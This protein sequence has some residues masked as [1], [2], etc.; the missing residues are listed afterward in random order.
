MIEKSLGKESYSPDPE[1]RKIISEVI[2]KRKS[3][4]WRKKIREALEYPDPDI[5]E[6]KITKWIDLSE[7]KS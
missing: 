7:D 1:A 3:L 4:P 6:Y 2:K 5:D